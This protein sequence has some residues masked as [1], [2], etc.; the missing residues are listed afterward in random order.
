MYTY[1]LIV[2]CVCDMKIMK[3]SNSIWTLAIFTK[4]NY[5]LFSSSFSSQLCPAIYINYSFLFF[6]WHYLYIAKRISNVTDSLHSTSHPFN[7]RSTL[8]HLTFQ[9]NS[10]FSRTSF[11]WVIQKVLVLR[12]QCDVLA[13]YRHY[14]QKT[15]SRTKLSYIV[16]DGRYVAYVCSL[17]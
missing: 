15:S 7:S 10:F 8:H 4:K 17:L 13:Q 9:G 11:S 5:S 1:L 14:W 16:C 12:V 2:Y 6:C 3:I